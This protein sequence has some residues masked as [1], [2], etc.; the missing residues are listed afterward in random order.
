ML[1]DI[2]TY[3]IINR[4]EVLSS[5]RRPNRVKVRRFA[6]FWVSRKPGMSMVQLS[7]RLKISQPTAKESATR[8]E[9]ITKKNKLELLQNR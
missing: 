9:K 5:G 2:L 7:R 3:R 8:G 6:C 4:A 1:L